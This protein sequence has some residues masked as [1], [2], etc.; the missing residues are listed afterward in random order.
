YLGGLRR[1]LIERR[2]AAHLGDA[3][4]AATMDRS[5]SG[6]AVAGDVARFLFTDISAEQL[7]GISWLGQQWRL[8]PQRSLQVAALMRIGF[9]GLGVATAHIICNLLFVEWL[10][11]RT[12]FAIVALMAIT[13][14]WWVSKR[15]IVGLFRVRQDTISS[16]MPYALDLILICL[17]SGVALETAIDRV[18]RELRGRDPLVAEELSRTLLD[19]NVIGNREQ[20]FRNLGERVD[21]VNMRSIVT[22]L[23]QSLQYGSSL[24]DSLKGAI[25][26]MKRVELL[27]LEERAGKLPV[28]LT[29][30]GLLFTLPQVIIL[31]AGPGA[32]GVIDSLK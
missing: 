28:Q 6:G 25:E 19:I 11:G 15:Y 7:L 29:L 12:A 22:V 27:T 18:A 3:G 10:G 16:A 24:I 5:P 21:T 30:P 13:L 2:V 1:Y 26:N 23:C 4:G 31:L 20:A 17:D 8:G 32:I 14:N 9:A